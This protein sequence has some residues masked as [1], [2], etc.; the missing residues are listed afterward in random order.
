MRQQ[1]LEAQPHHRGG[2]GGRGEA[3]QRGGQRRTIYT[4]QRLLH[5]SSN[6]KL[7]D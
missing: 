5:T 4:H 2:R 3:A 1:L 7:V 6:K